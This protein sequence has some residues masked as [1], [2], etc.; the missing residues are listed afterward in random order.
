[1]SPRS[2]HIEAHR[3]PGDRHIQ[4]SPG[5][6]Y[7]C[8]HWHM[9]SHHR[10]Q[11]QVKGIQCRQDQR[12]G[13]SGSCWWR[14]GPCRGVQSSPPG[15]GIR[16]VLHS[17]RAQGCSPLDIRAGLHTRL[18]MACRGAVLGHT[19]RGR[20]ASGT[21]ARRR[22]QPQGAHSA[23]GMRSATPMRLCAAHR[24]PTGLQQ[25]GVCDR[26]HALIGSRRALQH[27]LPAALSRFQ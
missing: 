10:V 26:P 6:H 9:G 5:F 19:A 17:S 2:P 24:G 18:G 1:M 12:P 14:Q 11:A 25:P 27:A 15:N 3:I 20:C 16:Q 7:S 23:R 21:G 8:P 13:S 22:P 4:R